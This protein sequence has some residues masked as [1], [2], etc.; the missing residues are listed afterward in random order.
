ML[1]DDGF[2]PTDIVAASAKTM[3]DELARFSRAL[4]GLRL[5][6]QR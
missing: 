6:Q 5:E 2:H 3:L 1:D 4:A